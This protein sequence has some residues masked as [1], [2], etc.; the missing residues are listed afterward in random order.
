MRRL[1]DIPLAIPLSAAATTTRDKAVDTDTNVRV[2]AR[3]VSGA[4]GVYNRTFF[5][6]PF[7]SRSREHRYDR[8]RE[9]SSE[10]V[11][12]PHERRT[13]KYWDVPPNG[14][15]HMTVAEYKMLQAQG[16]VPRL[17]VQVRRE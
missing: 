1:H 7:H 10:R 15:E 5:S 3:H 11:R 4:A 2:V 14:F 9:R 8:S 6:I 12:V 16:Q 13:N 17:S